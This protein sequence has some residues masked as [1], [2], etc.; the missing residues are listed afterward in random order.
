MEWVMQLSLRDRKAIEPLRNQP[1]LLVALR[2]EEIWLR[3]IFAEEMPAAPWQFLPALHTWRLSEEE[4]LF[5]PGD[6]TPEMHLPD[7][8]WEPAAQHFLVEFPLPG[9]GGMLPA[10][11]PVKVVASTSMQEAQ[12]LL[13]SLSALIDWAEQTPDFRWQGLS[14]AASA[15]G[16]AIVIGHPLPPLLGIAC[17]LSEPLIL[18]CGFQVEPAIAAPLL[19]PD[20]D[21]ND[22]FLF[23]QGRWHRLSAVQ[24]QKLSRSAL[25]RTAERSEPA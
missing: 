6:S 10:R 8:D 13:L 4:W 3:G 17:W 12:A 7:L 23:D 14:F 20:R 24:F 9:L 19:F 11:E 25:R 2:G 5:C 21:K 15:E 18:P 16:R 22:F 1:R